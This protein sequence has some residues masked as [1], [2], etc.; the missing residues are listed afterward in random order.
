MDVYKRQLRNI[1]GDEEA[2]K[3]YKD[4]LKEDKSLQA[5]F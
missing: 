1:Y 4:L 2:H 3:V 5:H